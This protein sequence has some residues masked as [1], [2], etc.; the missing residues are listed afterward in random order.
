MLAVFFLIAVSVFIPPFWFATFA[1]IIYLI[2]TKKQRRNKVIMNEVLQSIDQKR[3]QVILDYLYFDSAKSFAVDHG[4][5]L[6]KIGDVSS[7]DRLNVELTINGENYQVTFQRRENDETLLMVCAAENVKE[8][9]K[10]ISDEA[11]LLL[12]DS[13]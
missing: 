1:Y 12:K 6:P 5:T 13:A 9:Q 4:A 7:E 11:A 8:N 2:A 10:S 3:E